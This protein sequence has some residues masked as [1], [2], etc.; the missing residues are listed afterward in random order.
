[1]E[2]LASGYQRSQMLYVAATL[3]LADLLADG[4]MSGADLAR[5]IDAHTPTL[6]LLLDGLTD[7][8]VFAKDE[9]Q[10]YR[11]T[12]LAAP[13][14][15]GDPSG[16]H[17]ELVA[18]GETDYRA[19][20]ELLHTVQ[21]GESGFEHAYGLGMW[22]YYTQR[23][24]AGTFLHTMLAHNASQI[25]PALLAAY[26]FPTSGTVVDV[27]GGYG[28]VLSAL[29]QA[30]GA[31][32]GVLCEL[33]SLRQGA[34]HL[35]AEAGVADRCRFAGG[36]FLEAVPSGGDVYLLMRV[37]RNWDDQRAVTILTNCRRAIAP[38]GRLLVIEPVI[39]SDTDAALRLLDLAVVCGSKDRT[40][41][42]HRAIFD[43]AGFALTRIMP[44]G[45]VSIVEGVPV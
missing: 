25:A 26:D 18:T 9:Q 20:G 44:A 43:A 5:R 3:G 15:R 34:E 41:D 33:P 36:S 35:F 7:L 1:L 22:Q 4:P 11:V 38:H 42:E 37:L 2:H 13:L 32:R 6:C 19:W 45:S 12:P 27:G 29:L 31:M 39:S 16:L 40:E 23:A 30:R 17:D 8:G 14:R 28:A 10:R 21:T 24:D